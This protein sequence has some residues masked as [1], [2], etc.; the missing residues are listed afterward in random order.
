MYFPYGG[1]TETF[2]TTTHWYVG[3]QEKIWNSHGKFNNFVML[4]AG[5]PCDPM[6]TI[7]GFGNGVPLVRHQGILYNTVVISASIEFRF[8]TNLN[9]EMCTKNGVYICTQNGVWCFCLGLIVL[10]LTTDSQSSSRTYPVGEWH[11]DD[12]YFALTKIFT[13]PMRYGSL[14]PFATKVIYIIDNIFL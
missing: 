7:I 8:G 12:H 10:N 2:G 6:C 4:V 9:S 3:A 5:E 13:H 11:S 14:N 1:S